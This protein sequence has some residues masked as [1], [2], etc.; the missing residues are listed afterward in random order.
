[1]LASLPTACTVCNHI[2]SLTHICGSLTDI[3]RA[4][5]L[6]FQLHAFPADHEGGNTLPASFQLTLGTSVVSM[7]GSPMI[8]HF[9]DDFTG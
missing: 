7:V 2:R 1:M 4:A 3:L 9:V 8:S 5:N 6:G